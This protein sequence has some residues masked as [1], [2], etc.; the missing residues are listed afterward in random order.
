MGEAK[1]WI[2]SDSGTRKKRGAVS[3]LAIVWSVARQ[4]PRIVS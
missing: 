2:G 3:D 4:P 1:N